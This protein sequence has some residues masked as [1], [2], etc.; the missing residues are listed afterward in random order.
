LIPK[1]IKI[2]SIIKRDIDGTIIHKIPLASAF[3]LSM[4]FVLIYNHIIDK[5]KTRGIDAINPPIRLSFSE[6]SETSIIIEEESS[7]FNNVYIN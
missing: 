3:T 2:G 6:I 4:S 1:L 7:S 5:T